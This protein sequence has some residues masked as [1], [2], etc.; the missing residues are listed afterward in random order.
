VDAKDL[1]GGRTPLFLAAKKKHAECVKMLIEAGANPDIKCARSSPREAIRENLPYFNIESIKVK[2]RPRQNTVEYLVELLQKK[3]IS[4]FKSVLNFV[5]VKEVSTKRVKGSTCLQK[6][7][8]MGLH[9][10]VQN[11]LNFGVNPNSVTQENPTRPVLLAAYRGHYETLDCFVSHFQRNISRQNSVLTNFAVW[12]RDTNE[13]IL[14]LV[15]KKS[16]KKAYLGI[17]ST[18]DLNKQ[19]AN[20]KKCL[21]IL[22]DSGQDI[23]Q[24]LTRIINKKDNLDNTAL[25]YA[26]QL[27]TQDDVTG[28]LNLGANIGVRNKRG[29]IPLSRI[30]PDTLETFLDNCAE[31]ENHPMNDDFKVEFN[32][33]WLAPPVDD[34]EADEWDSDRQKELEMEGL[35][36]T[37]SLWC[38]AQSKNH[39]HLLRHPTVTSFL[40]LKW[41]RVRKF[42]SRNIRMYILFVTSLTWYI[43]TRFGGVS[44]N[45]TDPGKTIMNCT[46]TGK[47]TGHVFCHHLDLY[48]GTHS[49]FFYIAF[50][51]ECFFLL[52]LAVRDLKRDCG[53]SSGSAFMV[54]FLSSW[55]EIILAGMAAFL[56][57]FSSGGLWYI[58][59]ALLGVLG[60][61]E[62]LQMAASLKRYFLSLENILEVIM[63]SLLG[64]LLFD[65]DN[66]DDCE[67][68]VKR[69]IAAICILLSWIELIILVAK[70]PKLARYN[71][72]IS[73]FYK[74]LQTFL[75][76][77]LWYS[78][79][80]MA[81]AFGFYIMLHKDIPGFK[82]DSDHYVYFDG[83]W[84][85]LVKTFTMFV[86]ELEFSDI[87]IDPDSKLSWISF[88][89]LVVFVFFI[90]VILMNLL[91][92][93]A[94]SDT[95]IIMEKAE[96]VSYTTRV[97]TISYM[98]SI[99]LGDP[100]DFLSKWPPVS[101]LAK[102][103]SMAL[104]HQV[105]SHCPSARQAGHAVTGATGILLFYSL[106]PDKKKKFPSED[107][108]ETCESCPVRSVED[109]P[110]DIM[111]A[112]KTLILKKEEEKSKFDSEE[113]LRQIQQAI[114]AQQSQIDR[115][116]NQIQLLLQLRSNK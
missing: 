49:G 70:H 71:V 46:N 34:Y 1:A 43:S 40:W 62:L 86:G 102:I 50:L 44:M 111:D 32:Y 83:P 107:D 66:P 41:Q 93:L 80:L 19:D 114:Q 38:M 100:F 115:M 14:H 36:E 77:L 17:G 31:H 48:S 73:M 10:F 13:T 6:A 61:R 25:H 84:T 16:H 21:E 39:R 104:C 54:S 20:Y 2:E 85:S 75:S 18:S 12:S 76:F 33:S 24:Q 35:P 4:M 74:V 29:E 59:V 99:L 58:L 72:Y 42:F 94:V 96:I 30:L 37:E 67:C 64:F 91:N 52:I 23:K 3:D 87:P 113:Y 97:E 57:A 26:S 81:F 112:A 11:L 65:P 8:E 110:E 63:L 101:F 89:F 95:G 88:S 27:W 103:P 79:F 69:H 28:L 15:L 98:E 78:L 22:L 45:G 92:G 55:F 106:L 108:Q 7:S 56:V 68:D 53:C 116:E 82:P 9:H 109:I 60:F 5:S 47:E 51:V 90:V 105:Y